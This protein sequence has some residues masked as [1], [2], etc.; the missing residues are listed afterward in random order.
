MNKFYYL[1]LFLLIFIGMEACKEKPKEASC[2]KPQGQ[3][4]RVINPNGDSELALLM[5]EMH[6][7]TSLTREQLMNDRFNDVVEPAFVKILTA[8]PTDSTVKGE[9]FESFAKNY[10]NRLHTLHSTDQ[11]QKKN[12]YNEMVNSCISCHEEYCPG[13]IKKISKLK[14][15]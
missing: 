9:P 10:L 7:Y 6:A 15:Q 2:D 13:P 12:V 11:D 5:R 1:Y 4:S 14:L 3:R 8:T